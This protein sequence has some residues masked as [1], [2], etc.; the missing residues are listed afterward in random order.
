MH[1]PITSYAPPQSERLQD[2]HT[3]RNYNHYIQ[4]GLDAGGHGDEVIYQPQRYADH[5][6]HNDNVYQGHVSLS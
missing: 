1:K 2:P 6:Q 5:D 3:D 4:N